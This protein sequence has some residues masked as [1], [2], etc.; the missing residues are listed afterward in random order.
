VCSSNR[1]T[2]CF[3]TC[4]QFER[5][6]GTIVDSQSS[7]TPTQHTAHT[8]HA[9]PTH[10][11][12][13][14]EGI[15]RCFLHAL[16]LIRVANNVRG[17]LH[18]LRTAGSS[19]HKHLTQATPNTYIGLQHGWIGLA[20]VHQARRHLLQRI[21]CSLTRG[22]AINA[23]QYRVSTQGAPHKRTHCTHD[24]CSLQSFLDVNRHVSIMYAISF[25]LTNENAAPR[26]P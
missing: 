7:A 18:L 12:K 16:N 23:S 1:S 6:E 13:L 2:R 4:L 9:R 20:I 24:L 26:L 25:G 3:T 15:G 5:A 8:A 22:A 21:P 19:M 17:G 14:Y 10:F 11:A